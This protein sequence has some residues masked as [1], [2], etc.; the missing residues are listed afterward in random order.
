[1]KICFVSTFFTGATL[2]FI[3][4][5]NNAGH[6]VDFFLFARQ[7][8]KELETLVFDTAVQGNEIRPLQKGNPIYNYLDKSVNINL[9]PYYLRAPQK[10][11]R[12]YISYFKNMSIV[13]NLQKRIEKE[14]Y[15]VIY[16]IVNEKL[17]YLLCKR[18]KAKGH[19]NIIIAYHEVVKNQTTRPELKEVVKQTVRYG[20]PIITYSEHIK[21]VLFEL[22]GN[23]DI[24]TLYFGPFETYKLYD[25]DTPL[26]DKSYILF[27]GSISP[28]KGL[29]FLYETME[30]Y[31]D[32]KYFKIVVAGAGNDSVLAK[33]KIDKRY[34]I[35]NRFLSDSE[36]ANLVKYAKCVICPYVTSSQSGIPQVAMLFNT[37]VIATKVGAFPEI[38]K[39]GNN[40]YLVDYGNKE[41]LASA[42]RDVI[43]QINTN[44]IEIPEKLKWVNIVDVF[45]K[46]FLR[47]D[48]NI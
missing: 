1:M 22:T 21:K 24:H 44:Q 4:H 16:I 2:P 11:M 48:Y 36:F 12:D 42:I 13:Y 39:E 8:Q 40:G 46:A 23:K 9:V 31:E 34:I 6:F 45:T 35:I 43:G 18:L 28:Y 26:I 32:D 3:K 27:V 47:R 41:Q 20:F 5:L 37:P 25:S 17:D 33:M 14:S 15:N 7:G 10:T 19:K 29:P 30:Q 38:I